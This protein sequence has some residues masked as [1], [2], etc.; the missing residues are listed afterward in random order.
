MI[1]GE[2][3]YLFLIESKTKIDEF[4]KINEA[5]KNKK[6]DNYSPCNLNQSFHFNN[7]NIITVDNG[8]GNLS[9]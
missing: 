5:E 7:F 8:Y 9:G 4:K 6:S 3:S 1:N 2:N